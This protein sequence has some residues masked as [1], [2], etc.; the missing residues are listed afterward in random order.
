MVVDC[1]VRVLCGQPT[2]DRFW[3]PV[4]LKT[5]PLSTVFAA[6]QR[7]VTVDIRRPLQWLSGSAQGWGQSRADLGADAEER[8][9][10]SPAAGQGAGSVLAV[11]ST[12]SRQA[13]MKASR[14][15]V[16]PLG[17]CEIVA[18]CWEQVASLAV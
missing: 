16:P 14:W 15:M 11:S 17:C 3:Q 7:E 8:L 18:Y 6:E 10:S 2:L 12:L 4:V 9:R 1:R 5:S 13:F